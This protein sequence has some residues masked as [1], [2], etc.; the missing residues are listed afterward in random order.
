MKINERRHSIAVKTP[1]YNL[2]KIFSIACDS[3]VFIPIE[4]KV[5]SSVQITEPLKKH[6]HQHKLVTM[7]VLR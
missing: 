4:T 3:H 1:E 5:V 2:F 7:K 6:F